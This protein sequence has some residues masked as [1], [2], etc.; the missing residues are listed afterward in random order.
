MFKA[1]GAHGVAGVRRARHSG[2]GG[3]QLRVSVRQVLAQAVVN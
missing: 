3:N 1:V 2:A